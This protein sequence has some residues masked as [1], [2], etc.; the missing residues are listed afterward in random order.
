MSVRRLSLIIATRL[1]DIDTT[2]QSPACLRKPRGLKQHLMQRV[3]TKSVINNP[4]A[5]AVIVAVAYGLLSYLQLSKHAYDLSRFI[6][7]GD[8]FVDATHAP[9]GLYILPNSSG[10]DGQFYFRLALEP[11]TAQQTGYGITLDAPRYRQQRILYPLMAHLVA[12]GKPEAIPTAMLL[13][14]WVAICLLAFVGAQYAKQLGV[15]PVF[16]LLFALYPGFLLSYTRDLTEIVS[17]CFLLG[18]LLALSW[19]QKFLAINLLTLAVFA[20]ETTLL[21]AIVIWIAHAKESLNKQTTQIKCHAA[22]ALPIIAYGLWQIWLGIHWQDAGQDL[23]FIQKN[24]GAPFV[25]I[26][27]LLSNII[28]PSSHIQFVWVSETVLL[29]AFAAV[30]SLL[31]FRTSLHLSEKLGWFAY[32]ALVITLTYQVWQEDWGFLRACCEAYCFGCVIVLRSNSKSRWVMLLI[33]VTCWL[34]LG[35]EIVGF[36]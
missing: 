30:V 3:L 20:K 15:Q 9:S 13:V 29:I 18:A 5:C 34:L 21:A 10:Y 35:Y 4:W 2:R 22:F 23:R 28:P 33:C 25:G 32:A 31:S 12:L 1:C 26:V 19:Q 16:G 27:T 6:H 36:R 14:N 17:A 24:I 7:A 8:A 11:F